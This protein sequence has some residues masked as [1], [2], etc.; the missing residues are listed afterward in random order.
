VRRL[1]VEFPSPVLDG[2]CVTAGGLVTSLRSEAGRT[3]AEC[4]VWL[5]RERGVRAL[6]GVAVVAIPI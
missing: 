1:R 2:E 3:L 4:E 6:Q 5:D